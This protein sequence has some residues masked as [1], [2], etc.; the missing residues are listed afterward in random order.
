M[1]LLNPFKPQAF[2]K[3]IHN[4]GSSILN[5]IKNMSQL[6]EYKNIYKK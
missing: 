4:L 5:S 6:I 3:A 1:S 2:L